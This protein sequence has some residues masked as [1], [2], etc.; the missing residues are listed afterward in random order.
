VKALISI[1]DI[2]A[3][4]IKILDESGSDWKRTFVPLVAALATETI[5]QVEADF[6]IAFDVKNPFVLQF[7]ESY[8]PIF[9]DGIIDT[10]RNALIDDL[11][12]A[13]YEEGL[14]IP[15]LA[16]LIEG[17]Y[18]QWGIARATTIARTETGRVANAATFNGLRDVGITRK[19]WL[20]TNDLRTRPDH[21]KANHQIQDID[22][23]F[24]VG[25]EKLMYPND[26]NASPEQTINCRCTLVPVMD[27]FLVDLRN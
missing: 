17:K 14:G 25:G 1:Q 4:V 22:S 10:T 6:G 9:A 11:I 2:V 18:A 16:K 12:M 21:A 13:G 7:A 24:I 5:A 15:E 20:A 3:Y 26:Q 19:E 27:D 8:V 23:P